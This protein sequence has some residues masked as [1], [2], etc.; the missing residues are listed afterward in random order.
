MTPEQIIA[1]I[2]A[3]LGVAVGD[4]AAT[5]KRRRQTRRHVEARRRIAKRLLAE[6]MPGRD[7]PAYTVDEVAYLLGYTNHT[8]VLHLVGR[9]RKEG[10]P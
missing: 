5:G 4:V 3:E 6:R 9:T 8:S 7:A 2:A 1:E 10:K